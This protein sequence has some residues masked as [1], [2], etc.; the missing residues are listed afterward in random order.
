MAAMVQTLPPQTTV[1]VLPGRPS[2]S[3]GY[4]PSAPPPTRTPQQTRYSNFSSAGYRGV[5]STGPVAPYAFTS[6]PQLAKF[7]GNPRPLSTNF[8]GKP[9]SAPMVPQLQETGPSLSSAIGQKYLSSSSMPSSPATASP[10]ADVSSRPV[11]TVGLPTSSTSLSGSSAANARPPPPDRYRRNVRR[12]DS[13]GDGGPNRLP[14][15]SAMP[16]GSGMAAVGQLYNLPSQSS[17]SPSLSSSSHQSYRGSPHNGDNAPSGPGSADDMYIGRSTQPELA[18]RY[19]RRSFG[20]IE[21][22][23]LNHSSDA[24]DA[25]SPHPNTF[26]PHQPSQTVNIPPSRPSSHA[27]NGSS[28]SVASSRSAK[29]SRAGSVCRADCAPRLSLY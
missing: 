22:A 18:A 24:Q 11:S 8:S 5:P 14:A 29:S 27:H 25:S 4:P 28:E 12:G 9:L 1:T 16:S 26:L 13:S 10:R 3:G 7:S 15:G 17:S 21:T 6:T 2:S 23:G 20:S 19:R